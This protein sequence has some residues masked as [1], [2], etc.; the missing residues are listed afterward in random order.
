MLR[1]LDTKGWAIVSG[2]FSNALMRDIES[3]LEA[4][5]SRREKIRR[6]NHVD[7]QNDGTLHHLLVDHPAFLEVLEVLA[8]FDPLIRAFL[9]GNYI[10]NSYGGVINRRAT[11]AYVHN[12][13]RDIRFASDA[14]RF[15]LNCLV[16]LDDFTLENGATFLLSSSQSRDSRPDDKQFFD[17]SERAV[18]PKG[19]V[20]F[21]DSR[22][23]HATGPNLTDYPRKALTLTFT[24][25]FFKQQLDYPRLF[26]YENGDSLSLFLR[27]VVG[28]NARVPATLE[29]FYLPVEKRYY[30]RGQDE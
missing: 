14:K 11:K 18:G 1:Q 3:A 2:V 21:F 29:E 5:L 16:M 15:M 19:S 4:A 9:S 10:L 7:G 25:P 12:V 17:Q 28:F 24:S 22:L 6:E 23:W 8:S 27:Q 26:G 13:H 20:L 30:Q